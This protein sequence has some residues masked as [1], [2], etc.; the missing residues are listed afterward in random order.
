MASRGRER[1]VPGT[2]SRCQAP[3][4]LGAWHGAKPRA[5]HH[6]EQRKPGG[7]P[8]RSASP[9]SRPRVCLATAARPVRGT[10]PVE[11][12]QGLPARSGTPSGRRER[13]VPGTATRCQAP[14]LTCTAG[15]SIDN[16]LNC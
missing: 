3:R 11:P 1:L 5:W 10:K 6:P 12:G 2:A 9:M 15:A 7:V 14:R 16:Q 4:D 8:T 13:L